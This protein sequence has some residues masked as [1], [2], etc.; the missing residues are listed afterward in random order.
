MLPYEVLDQV[1]PEIVNRAIWSI[2]YILDE[3]VEDRPP[4]VRLVHDR[5]DDQA[6]DLPA[7][8]QRCWSARLD[9]PRKVIVVS[10]EENDE[11]I[12]VHGRGSPLDG[13]GPRDPLAQRVLVTRATRLTSV[14]LGTA[15]TGTRDDRTL[16]PDGR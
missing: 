14:A 4:L 2:I 6:F 3:R 8:P 9:P 16:P 12:H 15:T 1:G 7:P 5:V 11:C 10:V 13:T